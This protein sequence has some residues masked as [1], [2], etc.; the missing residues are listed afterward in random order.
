MEIATLVETNQHPKDFLK[1]TVYWR[2]NVTLEPQLDPQPSLRAQ[3][4]SVINTLCPVKVLFLL[5]MLVY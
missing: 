3:S 5:K 2:V 1:S 4:R